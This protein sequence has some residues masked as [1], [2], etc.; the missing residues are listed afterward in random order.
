[1]NPLLSL[2][3]SSTKSDVFYVER[4][5]EEGSPAGNNTTAILNSTQISGAMA[6]ETITIS[7]VAPL[8]S[9]PNAA[10]P[11][12]NVTILK[13]FVLSSLEEPHESF[14]MQ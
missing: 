11:S 1:M 12:T 5:S 7:S 9:K 13:C 14:C 6:W 3:S 10:Q 2:D 4:S 8:Q